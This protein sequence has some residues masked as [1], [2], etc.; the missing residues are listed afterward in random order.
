[1]LAN[2]GVLVLDRVR[3]DSTAGSTFVDSRSCCNLFVVALT[4][5]RRVPTGCDLC[6]TGSASAEFYCLNFREVQ[7]C[8]TA[9]DF[10]W[11]SAPFHLRESIDP[12][13]PTL[14]KPDPEWFHTSGVSFE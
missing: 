11:S 1:M 8:K 2:A 10:E 7:L 13:L 4:V 12:D 14:R 6:A 5:T 3:L 9:V